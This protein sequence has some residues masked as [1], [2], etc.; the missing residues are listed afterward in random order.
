MTI[1]GAEPMKWIAALAAL[2]IAGAGAWYA[3]EGRRDDRPLSV[4]VRDE[5]VNEERWLRDD[6]E[7]ARAR[8]REQ[9][10]PILALFRCVP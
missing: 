1:S 2:G 3:L 9:G 7:T 6:W 10:K 8:A 5:R 4:Q